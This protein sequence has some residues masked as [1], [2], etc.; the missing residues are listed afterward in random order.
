M[1]DTLENLVEV[2][3]LGV[4]KFNVE[5]NHEAVAEFVAGDKTVEVVKTLKDGTKMTTV[6]S[7]TRGDLVELVGTLEWNVRD[8]A[9][10]TF[11]VDVK[12][13]KVPTLGDFMV[14]R[15]VKWEVKNA[16]EFELVW[17]GQANSNVVQALTTPIVTDAKIV[18]NNK[19]LQVEVK[20][21]VNE[22]TFT[23]L[24]NT[25]PFKFAFLPIFE[26]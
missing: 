22:K 19:D 12:G 7:W 8:L 15:N 5:F 16:H 2:V 13:T 21:K 9:H 20:E 3:P 10:G 18:Y 24:F 25:K 11:V 14:N 1:G 6:V 4:D 17:D 26:L 23:L